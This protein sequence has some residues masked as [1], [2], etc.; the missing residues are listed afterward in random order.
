[1]NDDAIKVK[2][3]PC[4]YHFLFELQLTFQPT[5]V[6]TTQFWTTVTE[7]A[8]T[9]H[10]REGNCVTTSYLRDGIVLRELQDQKCQQ[11]VCQHTNVVQTGQVGWTVTIL[12]WK[13]VKFQERS[14]LVIVIQVAKARQL[15]LWKTVDPTI[16]TISIQHHHVI[17][18][19]VELINEGLKSWKKKIERERF[20]NSFVNTSVILY[21]CKF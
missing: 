12:Q 7:S 9:I 3:K 10:P 13:M 19:T 15:F 5:V 1:M 6:I 11:R 18:V 2:L 21:S 16:S 14:A 8:V 20:I 4:D 17:G